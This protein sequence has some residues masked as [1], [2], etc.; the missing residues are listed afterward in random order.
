[1]VKDVAG[2]L[3]ENFMAVTPLKLVPFNVTVVPSAATAGLMLLMAGQLPGPA[4]V[5][6]KLW[7]AIVRVPVRWGP[8]LGSTS[9]AGDQV[10]HL[11]APDTN[12]IHET[13]L[14]LVQQHPSVRLGSTPVTT[15][16]EP[17]PPL[18]GKNVL[19]S[20]RKKVHTPSQPKKNL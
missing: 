9:Q 11:L 3:F 20:A 2:M 18:A 17:T 15:K 6:T 7:P 5:T 14:L 1:M 8:A 10:V 4:W 13:P 19:T 16:A 12:R